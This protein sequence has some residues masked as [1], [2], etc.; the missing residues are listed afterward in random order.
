MKHEI[1]M[2]NPV[3]CDELY[4]RVISKVEHKQPQVNV[5][6]WGGTPLK[7]LF[8]RH[9]NTKI[10]Y[11][12]IYGE[13][14]PGSFLHDE[15]KKHHDICKNKHI[16]TVGN[17]YN[18]ENQNYIE[19][20]EHGGSYAHFWKPFGST[21]T[22]SIK[23][24]NP[25]KDI[26]RRHVSTDREGCLY[27]ASHDIA[28]RQQL[29]DYIAEKVPDCYFGGRLNGR[30]GHGNKLE[31]RPVKKIGWEGNIDI[32]KNYKVAFSPDNSINDNGYITEKIFISLMAGCVPIYFGYNTLSDIIDP[33][34]YIHARNIKSTRHPDNV[35]GFVEIP[36][37]ISK[38]TMCIK[39][40]KY[41]TD[42]INRP[43]IAPA[44]AS[45]F[46]GWRN[47]VQYINKL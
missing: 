23:N 7:H 5:Y 16:I 14:D 3:A 38:A 26:Y 31:T 17:F 32:F 4:R 35:E 6:Q 1:K 15:I 18:K 11:I 30:K 25:E 37:I 22:L 43:F 10:V 36:D 46:F 24:F 27:M 21:W 33:A 2:P 41:Y 44:V 9:D 40:E 8:E 34:C 13:K 12:F 47:I 29:W 19:H 39:N 20:N 45:S 28:G 42:I